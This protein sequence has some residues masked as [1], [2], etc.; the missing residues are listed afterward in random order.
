MRASA[1]YPLNYGRKI[2][3]VHSEWVVSLLGGCCQGV[4]S[5]LTRFPSLHVET[6]HADSP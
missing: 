4:P 5:T 3:D 2:R 6:H 1:A